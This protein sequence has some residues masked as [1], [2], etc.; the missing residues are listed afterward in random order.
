MKAVTFTAIDDIYGVELSECFVKQLEY[1][2]VKAYITA[3]IL[4][5][6]RLFG[7]L[8]A[9]QC[10]QARHWQ[11]PEIDLMAQVTLQTGFALDQAQLLARL[12]AEQENAQRLNALTPNIHASLH[13]DTILDT[14]VKAVRQALRGERVLVYRFGADWQGTVVAESVLP[15]FPKTLWAEMKDP[16]FAAGLVDQYPT[17]PSP[18]HSGSLCC[19]IEPLSS[20]KIGT[21]RGRSQFNRPYLSQRESTVWSAHCPSLFRPPPLATLRN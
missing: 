7:L 4:R 13:E 14:T 12:E 3:P 1:F 11:Q 6:N 5:E 2:G 8:I 16:C 20:G 18:C 21:L 17:R 15:E 9:H 10:S 19:Q